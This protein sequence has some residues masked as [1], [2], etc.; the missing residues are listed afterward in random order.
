MRNKGG[1]EMVEGV[2]VATPPVRTLKM[3]IEERKRPTAPAAPAPQNIKVGWNFRIF[4]Y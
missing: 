1:S 4:L 3:G 2:R